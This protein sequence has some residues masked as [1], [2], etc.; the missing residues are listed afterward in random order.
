LG[1]PETKLLGVA[2][3]R[4]IL[5]GASNNGGGSSMYWSTSK[6]NLEQPET[7]NKGIINERNLVL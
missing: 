3:K 7:S 5:G 2:T 4:M 1:T 6:M